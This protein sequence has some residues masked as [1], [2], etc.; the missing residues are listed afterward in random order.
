MIV[1]HFSGDKRITHR[2]IAD[3]RCL[4]N[5]PII[6]IHADYETRKTANFR[7]ATFT[8]R[9]L[10][11]FILVMEREFSFLRAWAVISH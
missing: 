11:D 4:Q 5:I 3:W 7:S 2:A 8:S 9:R 1:T 6:Q 10:P